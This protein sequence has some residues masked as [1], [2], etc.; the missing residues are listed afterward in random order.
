VRYRTETSAPSRRVRR[1]ARAGSPR[2]RARSGGT[3]RRGHQPTETI[4]RRSRPRP[5]TARAV[6][7]WIAQERVAAF[8]DEREALQIVVCPSAKGRPPCPLRDGVANEGGQEAASTC[9]CH[10]ASRPNSA[11]IPRRETRNQR[12][13]DEPDCIGLVISALDLAISRPDAKMPKFRIRNTSARGARRS[14]VQTS[15]SRHPL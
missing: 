12:L 4:V 13:P 14:R 8:V 9:C 7:D 5:C 2:T 11:R 6:G 3:R 15:A 1:R 10:A